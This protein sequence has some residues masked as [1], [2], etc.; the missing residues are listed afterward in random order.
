[1]WILLAALGLDLAF[2]EPPERAHPVVWMGRAIAALR[3]RAPRAEAA[4][5]RWGGLMVLLLV[6]GAALVG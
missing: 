6:G 1:M 5:L 2:G 3:D 4:A